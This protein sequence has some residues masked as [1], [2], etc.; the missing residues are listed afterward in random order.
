MSQPDFYPLLPSEY[1]GGKPAHDAD[2]AA[3]FAAGAKAFARNADTH[4]GHG[5]TAYRRVSKKHGTW[6]LDGFAAA[7]GFQR[8]G[9]PS[10]IATALGLVPQKNPKARRRRNPDDDVLFPYAD[11]FSSET[12]PSL[13]TP[14]YSVMQVAARG[15]TARAP[16]QV[17]GNLVFDAFF[18][19]G[20]LFGDFLTNPR[21]A[22]KKPASKKATRAQS[23]AA[24]AMRLF[25]S[26][27]AS[28]L[29]DAWAMVRRG[30]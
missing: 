30:R 19:N 14:D 8:D 15:S 7:I 1:R 20:D 16:V 3:G 25:H 9:I 24:K 21:K 6:W 5:E 13:A 26:G 23:N 11:R 29:A 17:D 2:F 28:S 4:R 18:D 27:K 12:Y 22:A 10:K